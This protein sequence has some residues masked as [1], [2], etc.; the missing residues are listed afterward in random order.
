MMKAR[1]TLVLSVIAGSVDAAEIQSFRGQAKP[2]IHRV[3]MIIVAA[4]GAML[5]AA[6]AETPVERGGYLVNAV[7]ACGGCRTPRPAGG[8]F[9]MSKR[10]SRGSQT[11]DTPQYLVKASNI[12]PDPE[13]GIG[14]WSADDSKRALTEGV[15]PS[16]VAL[17]PQMPFVFYK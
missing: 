1:H 6:R 9:D 14:K 5:S 12:A 16:A 4:L 7:M 17:A 13:T 8:A 2:K 3:V 10:I 15:R 11:W